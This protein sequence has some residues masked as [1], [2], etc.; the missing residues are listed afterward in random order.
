MITKVNDG[1]DWSS[2]KRD[3]R[4]ILDNILRAGLDIWYADSSIER[5]KL[6][7]I[8]SARFIKDIILE[9]IKWIIISGIR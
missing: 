9:S 1:F 8:Y 7:G 4:V 5:L 3:I 6:I 2:D